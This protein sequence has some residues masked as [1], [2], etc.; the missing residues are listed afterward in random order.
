MSPYGG[1]SEYDTVGLLSAK[2][3]LSLPEHSYKTS[4]SPQKG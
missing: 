4:K 2:M 1:D 3:K